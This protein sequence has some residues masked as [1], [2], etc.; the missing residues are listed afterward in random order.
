MT[1]EKGPLLE[2]LQAVDGRLSEPITLVAAGGTALVLLDVK[3]ST[4]DVDFTGPQGSIERFREVLERLPHGFKVDTWMD[5]Y[6]F[7]TK[8]PDDYL[9]RSV[10]FESDRCP[11]TETR[12]WT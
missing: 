11:S 12:A 10:P 5:G 4:Q 6:V 9:E 2:F 8:L 3:V 7:T 1:L